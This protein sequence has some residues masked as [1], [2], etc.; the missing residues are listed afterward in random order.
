MTL[1]DFVRA[2]RKRF[3]FL[4]C[5]PLMV[6]AVTALVNYLLIPPMYESAI[7]MYVLQR[8][9]Q[10]TISQADLA[11]SG[12][13]IAD[14]R[15]LLLS[16]RVQTATA[17]Q[18]QL[19]DLDAF[20]IDVRSNSGT[21]VIEIAVCGPDPSLTAQV[22]NCLGSEFS[23]CVLEIMQVENVKVIDEASVNVEPVRPMRL[24][25]ILVAWMAGLMLAIGM[26][27]LREA[28]NTTIRTARDAQASIGLPI[29]T[30]IPHL[31]VS[32]DA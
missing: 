8:Q 25:N 17:R 24:R 23:Q 10:D 19:Q 9:S 26:V 2:V 1:M 30:S 3:R 27:V 5:L 11:A 18:L 22:A 4:V 16:N 13:L 6:A 20:T 15:E 7:S 28:M 31:E 21:R 14:Y 29:L 32:K 12:L